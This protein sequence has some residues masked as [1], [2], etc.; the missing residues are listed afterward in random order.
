MTLQIEKALAFASANVKYWF[1]LLSFSLETKNHTAELTS[2]YSSQHSNINCIDQS[3]AHQPPNPQTSNLKV[4]PVPP[5]LLPP[6][7]R[8]W[9]DQ[10]TLSI[11]PLQN[12]RFNLWSQFHSQCLEKSNLNDFTHII[13]EWVFWIATLIH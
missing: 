7:P 5:S 6:S 1:V 8:P 9:I 4:T 13:T 10:Q 2:I 12:F 3:M 11:F